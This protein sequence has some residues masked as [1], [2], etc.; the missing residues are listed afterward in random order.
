M[1]KLLS[2]FILLFL[3]YY[4]GQACRLITNFDIARWY[5]DAD[6]VLIG[7]LNHM[8]SVIVSQFDSLVED[9][10]H[11]RYDIIHERCHFSIDS[12]LKDELL[13]DKTMDTI[14]SPD[15]TASYRKEKREFVGMNS[16]GDSIFNFFLFN[17]IVQSAY[18]I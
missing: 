5:L 1:K 6:L 8:D 18:F 14:F 10:F 13:I 9:G 7:T 17:N 2:I 12:V 3:F 4:S 16:N 11:I 15:F